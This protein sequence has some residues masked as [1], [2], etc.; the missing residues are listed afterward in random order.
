M[1]SSFEPVPG[2]SPSPFVPFDGGGSAEAGEVASSACPD[3]EAL[4]ECL[5]VVEAPDPAPL[6]AA[7]ACQAYRR[8]LGL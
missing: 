1:K 2:P 3:A 5:A 7:A 8:A 6:L 4:A